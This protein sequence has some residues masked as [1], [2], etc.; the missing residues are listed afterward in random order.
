MGYLATTTVKASAGLGTRHCPLHVHTQPGQVINFTLYHFSYSERAL[1]MSG[2][3]EQK[4]GQQNEEGTPLGRRADRARCSLMAV[5]QDGEDV[6]KFSLCQHHKQ[7]QQQQPVTTSVPG[8]SSHLYRSR[9]NS[10][11]LHFTSTED[12]VTT[13]LWNYNTLIKYQGN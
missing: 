2:A 12:D 6:K 8:R 4:K 7:Q 10:V 11:R 5:I 1:A 3:S 9:Y 13:S